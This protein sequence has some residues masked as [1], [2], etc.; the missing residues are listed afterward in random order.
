MTARLILVRHGQIEANLTQRWHGST[1]E[2]LT[3]QGRVDA[4]RVAEFLGR[5]RPQIGTVYTSPAQRAHTTAS[6]IA[7]ALGVPL[8]VVPALS[9]YAIGVFEGESYADL[10]ARHR[11]FEQADADITW[12]PPGGESLETVGARVVAAWQSIA[13]DHPSS[14]TVVVSH[15]AAIAIGLS[16]L[17]DAGPRGWLR[18]RLRNGSVTEI[19]IEPT[20]RLVALNMSDHLD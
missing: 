3:E 6:A 17:F 1:D 4:R 20:P 15:G 9:E 11:F 18:Y 16:V 13:R 19:E 2:A 10:A 12:A 5:T 8:F 7:D 14:E